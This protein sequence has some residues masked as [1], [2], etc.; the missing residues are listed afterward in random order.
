MWRRRPVPRAALTLAV[1]LLAAGIA[2]A[3]GA[4]GVLDRLELSSV[5]ERFVVRGKQPSPKDVVILGMG[6]STLA[7]LGRQTPYPRSL[8]ARAIDALVHAGARAIAYDVEFSDP[9]VPH[10]DAALLTARSEERRVGKECR[11]R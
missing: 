9:S 8:H 2:I 4:T 11:S 6:E 7:S 1:G 10:E 3:V 5:D